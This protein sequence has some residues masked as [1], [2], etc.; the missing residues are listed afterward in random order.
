MIVNGVNGIFVTHVSLNMLLSRFMIFMENVEKLCSVV[1][2]P[3]Y[4]TSQGKIVSDMPNIGYA[5]F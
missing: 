5:G 1:S 4:P 3:A 2:D